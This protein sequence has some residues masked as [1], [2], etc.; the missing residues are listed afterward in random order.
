MKRKTKEQFI[1]EANIIHNNVY[2]YSKTIYINSRTKVIITCPCH[3]DFHQNPWLH[4]SGSGCPSC[5]G[6]KKRTT[7]EFIK[8]AHIVHNNKYNYSKVKYINNRTKILILCSTHNEFMQSPSAHLRGQGCPKCCVKLRSLIQKLSLRE[9][10]NRANIIHN[11][12][13][14]YSKSTYQKYNKK[15]IITCPD[16]GNFKQI[17]SHHLNGSGCPKCSRNKKRTTK[18]FTKEAH[19]VHNNKYNYNKTKYRN[20]DLKVIITC[21]YHGDFH[22]R[23]INHLN[24]QGC[25][26]CAGQ[27]L[28]TEDFIKKSNMVHNG[29]YNY[30][31]VSYKDS[32]T[33]VMIICPKHGDF[34]QNP[35]QHMRGSGCAVCS[36]KYSKKCEAWLGSFERK[37]EREQPI[38]INSKTYVADGIDRKTN[39]IYEFWGD[40]WHGNPEVFNPQDINPIVKKSYGELYSKTI[41]KISALISAGYNLVSIW[42]YDYDKMVKL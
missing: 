12:K 26:K 5:S 37:I 2:G 23:A 35:G 20:A 33:K 14:S 31:K 32:Y 7:K 34:A 17:V 29:K 22:Q 10:I 42:E 15:I 8:K 36:R 24:G 30:S 27:H 3:G 1:Y 41:M 21:L 25:P 18:E 38:Q 16:H 6:N 4:L 9:F 11:N 19:I 13:Y 40:F 39:T 28:N